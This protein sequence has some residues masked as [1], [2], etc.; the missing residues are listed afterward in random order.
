MKGGVKANDVFVWSVG[1]RFKIP[2]HFGHYNFEPHQTM[3]TGGVEVSR[4]CHYLRLLS[5]I[6]GSQWKYSGSH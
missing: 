4:C 3:L 6:S 1:I 2:T 5:P